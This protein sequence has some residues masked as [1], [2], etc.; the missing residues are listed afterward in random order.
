MASCF[1]YRMITSHILVIF[2]KQTRILA[3]QPPLI[4]RKRNKIAEQNFTNLV[5]YVNKS[6]MRFPLVKTMY[7]SG[8]PF[9]Y[10]T[11]F[12]SLY[13]AHAHSESLY[14]LTEAI[15]SLPPPSLLPLHLCI[16][17]FF[18]YL[19]VILFVSF[20]IYVG[21]GRPFL[22][23]FSKLFTKCCVCFNLPNMS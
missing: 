3:I 16:Y 10:R 11:R 13:S 19:I 6:F 21:L 18:F 9:I 4:Q 12:T 15:S 8:I 22:P 1:L 5:I 17:L 7:M 20:M 2:R 23:D 14:L